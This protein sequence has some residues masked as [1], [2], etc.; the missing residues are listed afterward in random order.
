MKS[1][2]IRSSVHVA[3][4]HSS[5]LPSFSNFTISDPPTNSYPSTHN[6][7][8][9]HISGGAT[10]GGNNIAPSFA[11][12]SSDTPVARIDD[13]NIASGLDQHFSSIE[14]GIDQMLFAEDPYAQEDRDERM[15]PA[16]FLL[17]ICPQKSLLEIKTVLHAHHY[18]MDSALESLFAENTSVVPN[19]QEPIVVNDTSDFSTKKA[20]VCRHFMQ[21]Y[22][23][24]SDCR[25]SH[26]SSSRICKF[27]T[28]GYCAKGDECP[29]VHGTE[30]V[31]DQ[32]TSSRVQ[33]SVTLAPTPSQ[34]VPSF[35][36]EFPTLGASSVKK[37]SSV[38]TPSV[39]SNPSSSTPAYSLDFW[40]QPVS[41]N[42]A[43]AKKPSVCQMSNTSLGIKNNSNFGGSGAKASTRL[44]AD[45]VTTGEMLAS[46]YARHRGDACELAEQRK[47]LFQRYHYWFIF[48]QISLKVIS[49]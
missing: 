49:F 15:G 26:D 27:W 39:S 12:Y 29:F 47:A 14:E 19:Q 40:T 32:V 41:Y 8:F 31:L 28:Q 16:E 22:C 13:D 21:G 7:Y 34:P 9:N 23:F 5:P 11:S 36:E 3:D 1:A 30:T 20:T 4:H 24:R 33:R 6:I 38:K 35:A 37:S 44:Q 2:A 46:I 17:A 18:D 43:A 25:Y 48:F 42:E 45:W 10:G